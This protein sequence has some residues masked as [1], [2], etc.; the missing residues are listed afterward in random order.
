M[1]TKGTMSYRTEGENF[2]P[3][4][5]GRDK[6]VENRKAE[7]K[8]YL[9]ETNDIVIMIKEAASFSCCWLMNQQNNIRTTLTS[10]KTLYSEVR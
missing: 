10:L 1:D 3:S 6:N 7:N 5:G 8:K 4:V 2:Y 9:R